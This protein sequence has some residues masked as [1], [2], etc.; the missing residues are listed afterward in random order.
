VRQPYARAREGVTRNV[1][2]QTIKAFL[3]EAHL[4]LN[5]RRRGVWILRQAIRQRPTAELYFQLGKGLMAPEE[6]SRADL[7][8][9]LTAYQAAVQFARTRHDQACLHVFVAETSALL[10]V[11][12][13]EQ[14]L[15]NILV[16]LFIPGRQ[17]VRA[18]TARH[19][20]LQAC[21]K[22]LA[23]PSMFALPSG[24]DLLSKL[25][26]VCRKLQDVHRCRVGGHRWPDAP[27]LGN[28]SETVLWKEVGPLTDLTAYDFPEAA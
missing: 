19:T 27:K 18:M 13:A 24:K 7:V 14:N 17:S 12:E 1:G 2:F 9:G 10:E 15:R 11:R 26:T 28:I 16:E 6:V 8:R 4:E 3:A 23:S 5:D 20:A 21:D 25:Q 22:A